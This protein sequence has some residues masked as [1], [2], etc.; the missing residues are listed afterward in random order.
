MD[1]EPP[2]TSPT[3]QRLFALAKGPDQPLLTEILD[4]L[5]FANIEMKSSTELQLRHLVNIKVATYETKVR[6]CEATIND[7]REKLVEM[8]S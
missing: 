7:L 3:P 2:L 5:K 6:A 1:F 4:L 8:E